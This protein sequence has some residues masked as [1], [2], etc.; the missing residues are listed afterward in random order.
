MLEEALA[1]LVFLLSQK[2]LLEARVPEVV[3]LV[4]NIY[5]KNDFL[6]S[7]MYNFDYYFLVKII[8]ISNKRMQFLKFCQKAYELYASIILDVLEAVDGWR[9]KVLGDLQNRHKT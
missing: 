3:N 8:V 2:V 1:I 4:R 7:R 5:Y 6:Y 9:F